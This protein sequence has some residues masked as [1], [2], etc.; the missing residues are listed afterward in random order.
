LLA[1]CI[2]NTRT[3]LPT[4]GFDCFCTFVGVWLKD[5]YFI[6]TAAMAI[7]T[8]QG[9]GALILFVFGGCVAF[10]SKGK[11]A[12]SSLCFYKVFSTFTNP[13]EDLGRGSGLFC[14][15]Y[16]DAVSIRDALDHWKGVWVEFGVVCSISEYF[17][18][19]VKTATGATHFAHADSTVIIVDLVIRIFTSGN[20]YELISK[21]SNKNAYIP[22]F[23]I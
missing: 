4:Q 17:F 6:L 10:R 22:A 16:G 23:S 12:H 20:N 8:L 5:V 13:S 2:L 3:I 21:F 1:N 11:V 18:G 19:R 15:S 7:D 9:L 14:E